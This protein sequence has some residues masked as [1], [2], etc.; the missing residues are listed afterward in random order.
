MGRPHLLRPYIVLLLLPLFNLFSSE[1]CAAPAPFV[2]N[3]TG[4]Y[5]YKCAGL[6][7]VL[8][9][10]SED[11]HVVSFGNRSVIIEKVWQN[12]IEEYGKFLR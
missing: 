2:K 7:V 1:V 4:P 6:N 9:G 12:K 8:T 11:V 10:F 3:V 5:G